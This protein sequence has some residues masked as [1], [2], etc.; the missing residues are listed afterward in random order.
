MV[1]MIHCLLLQLAFA[2][3]P[4]PA[5]TP[6]VDDTAE[7]EAR[8]LFSHGRDA[9]EHGR[10]EDAIKKWEEAWRLSRRP[11]LLANLANAYE[12]LGDLQYAAELLAQY[13]DLAPEEERDS[14]QARI[15]QL[16]ARLNPGGR[17]GAQASRRD[18]TPAAEITE[19]QRKVQLNGGHAERAATQQLLRGV[20]HRSL[21]A[22]AWR[23]VSSNTWRR[24]S[25]ETS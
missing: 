15:A 17:G 20:D 6:A 16:E 23:S 19:N 11:L 21:G 7:A 8:N 22:L 13:L 5:Q 4:T 2:Q 9:Y 10:Y 14:L 25:P 12:R 18:A 3:E 1:P 24:A